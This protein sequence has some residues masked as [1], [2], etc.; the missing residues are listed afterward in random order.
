MPRDNF[1]TLFANANKTNNGDDDA[2]APS[3]L[4]DA[5]VSTSTSAESS[6]P[7]VNKEY[8]RSASTSVVINGELASSQ[9]PNTSSASHPPSTES[10][11]P[12]TES[13][14][15]IKRFLSPAFQNIRDLNLTEKMNALADNLEEYPDRINRA[16]ETQQKNRRAKRQES[17]VSD[18]SF[19]MV[20]AVQSGSR[21]SD[22]V[23]EEECYKL[24][25]ESERACRQIGEGYDALTA[26][27]KD[28]PRGSYEEFMQYLL[29]A[30][31][32]EENKS[33]TKENFYSTES[34]YRKLWNDNLT[35]G[36]D[37][38]DC[39]TLDGRAFVPARDLPE[40]HPD[41]TVNKTTQQA[42]SGDKL[43][44]LSQI[45]RQKIAT[46]AYS[47]L[48]NVST[49]AMKPLRE[50]QL[51]EKVN[52]MQLDLED[53]EA[54]REIERYNLRMEEKR[55]LEDMMRLKREAEEKTLT[56]TKDHLREFMEKN[57]GATY[58][59]WIEDLVSS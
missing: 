27:V 58:T 16:W 53:E 28:H 46:S 29:N 42:F 50:F 40:Q 54:R 5:N 51:A 22:E 31:T 36:L 4:S 14:A 59:E 11:K 13:I 56:L 35:L 19:V 49:L 21:K 33:F 2:N 32:D 41:E 43:K 34:H 37:G 38:L 47:V 8:D 30:T 45:D 55:D 17:D 44:H 18:D 25:M 10:T 6:Q 24:K 57:P 52:A 15:S 48:S 1:Q 7:P 12:G 26:F 39:T 23:M 9:P 20:D 3:T